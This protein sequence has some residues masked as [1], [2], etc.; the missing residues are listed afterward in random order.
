MKAVSKDV[1]LEQCLEDKKA[2]A[3]VICTT[4]T[5]AKIFIDETAANVINTE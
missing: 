3:K 5:D 2:C 1:K 4:K